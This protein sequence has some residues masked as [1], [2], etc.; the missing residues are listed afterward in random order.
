MNTLIDML[1]V[2]LCWGGGIFMIWDATK[3]GVVVSKPSI[4]IIKDREPIRFWFY[5]AAGTF[6]FFGLGLFPAIKL[7][8]ILF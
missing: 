7:Y 2:L 5:I 1:A 3:S 6:V 8:N 4:H